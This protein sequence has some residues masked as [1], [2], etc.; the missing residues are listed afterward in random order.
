LKHQAKK[1]QVRQSLFFSRRIKHDT[2]SLE[3]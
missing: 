2:K 1:M 3:K